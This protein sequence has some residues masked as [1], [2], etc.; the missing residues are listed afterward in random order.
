MEQDK[1]ILNKG[2]KRILKKYLKYYAGKLETTDYSLS[3]DFIGCTPALDMAK[4]HIGMKFILEQMQHELNGLQTHKEY[5]ES[6]K[7]NNRIINQLTLWTT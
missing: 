5:K 4:Y 7:N 3:E 6:I 1:I 2:D